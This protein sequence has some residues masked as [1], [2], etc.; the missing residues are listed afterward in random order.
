MKQIDDVFPAYINA[1]IGPC[2]NLRRFVANKDYMLQRGYEFNLY[3]RDFLLGGSLQTPVNYS[4]GLGFRSYLKSIFRKSKLFSVLFLIREQREAEKL[5]KAYLALDRDPDVIIFH[6]LDS[7]YYYLKHRKGK[8]AKVGLFHESDGIRLKMTFESY[9]KLRHTL[10]AKKRYKKSV[11]VDNAVDRN[12]F[13]SFISKENF[14]KENPDIPLE[15]NVAFH[16][17]IDMLPVN[18]VSKVTNFKYNLCITGTVCKRKGQ[19]IIVEALN[20]ISEEAKKKIHVS[21]IGEGNDLDA[22][23]EKVKTY[24]IEDNI[25]F[26]GLMPN[27][28]V[29]NYLCGCDIYILMSNS[30]GLPISIIEGMRAGLAVI[31]TPI[32]GIPEEVGEDNGLLIN[33]D[34]KELAEVFEN[35]DTYDWK[36]YGVGSRKKFEKEFTFDAM[37]NS[38]CDVMDNLFNK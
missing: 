25:S 30:E 38:Y 9:P 26:L 17:G 33:P 13:I 16:N 29:H 34:A 36:S 35:I 19:Y 28:E 23:K 7:A 10:W 20:L 1:T 18:C 37:I 22:L 6:E 4:K 31:S 3:T 8:K 21:V 14:V 5:M 32:A 12:I 24:G 27:S 15:R 11:L 2:S